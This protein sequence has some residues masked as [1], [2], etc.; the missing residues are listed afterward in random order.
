ML[1]SILQNYFSEIKLLLN[2]GKIFLA[3]FVHQL[4][5]GSYTQYNCHSFKATVLEYCCKQT[6]LL[7]VRKY[8]PSYWFC[9]KMQY[10]ID[11]TVLP[12]TFFIQFIKN[13]LKTGLK[14]RMS[15]VGSHRFIHCVAPLPLALLN[16]LPV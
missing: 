7:A 9:L 8:L 2:Y 4:N 15:G 14:P 13:V 16:Y 5:N 12:S 10:F 11:S 3:S 1:G 6:L